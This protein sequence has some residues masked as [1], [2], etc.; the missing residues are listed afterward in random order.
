MTLQARRR[1]APAMRRMALCWLLLL[2]GCAT[3]T[4]RHPPMHAQAT[5]QGR[6]AVKIASD[7]PR[8][9][10]A[11]FALEGSAN[12]GALALTSV[13]GTRVATL[14]WSPRNATLQTPQEVLTF[15]SADAMVAH[16]LGAPLPMGALF[17]WLQG[18]STAPPGWEV[19]LQELPLGRL[20]ARRLGPDSPA[21]IKIVFEPG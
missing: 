9:F 6:L 18:D 17:G 8:A 11:D 2:S 1:T 7:P 16:S 12:E 4:A 20:R 15:E 14:R 10:S 3:H 21:D 13:L 19:D 5:W